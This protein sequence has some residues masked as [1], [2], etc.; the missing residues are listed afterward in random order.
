MELDSL[1]GGLKTRLENINICAPDDK[2]NYMKYIDMHYNCALITYG[3]LNSG[4]SKHIFS[5]ENGLVM[6]I[7][8]DLL[9]IEGGR[10]FMEAYEY[11]IDNKS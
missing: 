8:R 4:K 9:E 5:E 11:Y 1:G 3:P 6:Q 7:G 2:I 10:V